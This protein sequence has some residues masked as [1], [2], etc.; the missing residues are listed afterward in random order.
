MKRFEFK[1]RRLDFKAH[2]L[3]GLV[4]KAHRLVYDSTLGSRVIK[5]KKHPFGVRACVGDPLP[6]RVEH[7]RAIIRRERVLF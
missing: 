1:A 4:F 5:K 7:S 2:R 3:G 6:M